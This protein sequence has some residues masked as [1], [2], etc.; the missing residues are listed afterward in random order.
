M[1][2]FF[3]GVKILAKISKGLMNATC[4]QIK[5]RPTQII[6]SSVTLVFCTYT[7]AFCT[8]WGRDLGASSVFLWSWVRV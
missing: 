4:A 1:P 8:G 5:K 2:K 6:S 3:T 7:I